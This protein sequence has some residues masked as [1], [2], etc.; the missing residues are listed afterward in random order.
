MSWLKILN[1][2]KGTKYSLR[3]KLQVEETIKRWVHFSKVI[4]GL[5]IP[6]GLQMYFTFWERKEARFPTKPMASF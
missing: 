1:I 6:L 4:R 2:Y 5:I 3:V